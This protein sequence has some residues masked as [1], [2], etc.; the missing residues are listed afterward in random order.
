[1]LG[2][3]ARLALYV[4]LARAHGGFV[5]AICRWDCGWYTTIIQSGYDRAPNGPDLRANWAFFPLYPLLSRAVA[6]LTTLPPVTSAV[7]LNLALFPALVAVACRFWITTRGREGAAWL[8]LLFCAWPYGIHFSSAYT[9]ALYGLLMM[10]SLLALTHERVLIGGVAGGL[11]TAT[12]PTGVLA[13][14][15]LGIARALGSGPASTRLLEAVAFLALGGL[16]LSCYAIYLHQHVGDALAF[17]HIEASWGRSFTDPLARLWW[18]LRVGDLLHLGNP[19]PALRFSDAYSTLIALL[20]LALGAWLL[21]ERRL[22]E[23][24]IVLLTVLVALAAG[25]DSVPRYALDTPILLLAVCDLL[26]RL[27]APV[28]AGILVLLAALQA[29][30]VGQWYAGAVFLQ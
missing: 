14:V 17:M 25:L 22:A 7:L 3:V 8:A 12:R 18:G 26:M 23:G 20:S 2:Y 15:V 21:V 1:M 29:L 10:V 19:D 13:V 16:G 30:L 5:A 11:L 24:A 27:P 6:L 28:R 4:W 9:E